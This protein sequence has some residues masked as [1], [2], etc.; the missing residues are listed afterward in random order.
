MPNPN[1]DEYSDLPERTRDPG[2]DPEDVGVPE[3]ADDLEYEQGEVPQPSKQP[4]PTEDPV[5]VT[6]YGTT[7]EEQRVGESLDRKLSRELPDDLDAQLA[8]SDDATPAEQA[9]M[10]IEEL[11][12]DADRPTTD[13]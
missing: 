12:N 13:E 11:P 8:E 9:A 1:R 10:H 6:D 2:V 5:A 3:V 4:M 7:A